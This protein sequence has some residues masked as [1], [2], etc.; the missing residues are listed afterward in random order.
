MDET[1]K[2]GEWIV[3][4]KYGVG[5]VTGVEKKHIGGETHE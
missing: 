1:L 3:H 5:Q 4:K 2:A